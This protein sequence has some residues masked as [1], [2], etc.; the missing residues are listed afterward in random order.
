MHLIPLEDQDEGGILLDKAPDGCLI[1]AIQ[2]GNG[3]L[4]ALLTHQEARQTAM[5]LLTLVGSPGE[6]QTPLRA[7]TASGPPSVSPEGGGRPS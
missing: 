4:M 1:L 7:F 2:T 3:H 6:L 5:A